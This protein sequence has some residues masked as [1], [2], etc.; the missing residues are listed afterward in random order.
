M[1][2]AGRPRPL[3]ALEPDTA[4]FW[5]AGADGQ[6]RICRC[7]DCGLY[8]HPP[9]PRCPACGGE[10]APAPVSGRGQVA[11]FTI[12]EQAWV[13]GLEVPFVFAAV[14]LAEQAGLHLLTNI[15]DCPVEAVRT[16]MPVEVTF[17]PHEDVYIPLFRPA[18]GD[19]GG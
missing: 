2:S 8:L 12:N 4:F 16:G 6:L 14:E 7:T 5:T 13:P 19:N 3:P 17:E 15:V 9:L 18:G 1:T 10:T 11:A